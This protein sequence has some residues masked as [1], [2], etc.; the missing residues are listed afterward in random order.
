MNNIRHPLRD[1]AVK[2]KLTGLSYGQV[3]KQLGVNEKSIPGWLADYRAKQA[4]KGLQD[5]SGQSQSAQ[6]GQLLG[7]SDNSSTLSQPGDNLSAALT[8]GVEGVKRVRTVEEIQERMRRKALKALSDDQD[9]RK[10][11][12]LAQKQ[13]ARMILG[14][15][16]AEKG[17]KGK[18]SETGGN[19][20]DL[21]TVY[22]GMNDRELAERTLSSIADIVGLET[23][24]RILG[25]L[26]ARGQLRGA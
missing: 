5:Q 25:E 14:A 24:E 9:G 6:I 26:K 16:K 18:A 12:T 10:V 20:Q 8:V 22:A 7:Q 13:T 11:L 19:G 2:L 17:G 23:L 1:E 3:A 15:T 21:Q 4:K